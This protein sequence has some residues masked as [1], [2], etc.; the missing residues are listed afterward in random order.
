MAEPFDVAVIGAGPVGS[1]AA[2]RMARGGLRVALLEKDVAPGDSTVCAGGLH[3]SVA[4]VVALPDDLIERRLPA[5]RLVTVRGTTEWRF[6]DPPYLTVERRALDRFLAARAE[7][8]GAR[9]LTRA[10]VVALAPGYGALAYEDEAGGRRTLAARAFVFADGPR[11]LARTY[12]G[13]TPRAAARTWIGLEY[14]LALPGHAL[15]ALEIRLDPAALPLG[16]AWCFPKRDHVNVGLVTLAPPHGRPLRA[17]LDALVARWPALAGATVLARKGGIVPAAPVPR[18]HDGNR[19]A[20]GDAAGMTNPLTAGGYVCGFLSAAHAADACL[21]A[22]ASG[23]FDERALAAYPRRLRR[24]AHWVAIRAA[25]VV[26]DLAARAPAARLYPRLLAGYLRLAHA[27]LGVVRPLGAQTTVGVET[28]SA[29]QTTPKYV[30]ARSHA[31]ASSS[32][33]QA[34]TN[35]TSAVAAT[36]APSAG[37]SAT[38]SSAQSPSRTP[39]VAG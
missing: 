24:T 29:S 26:V 17:L 25:A 4:D 20:V 12:V 3:R 30:F 14:D 32:S 23:R 37:A 19:L 11:S 34:S 10:R 2:E 1:F 13:P 38:V 27:A 9:L 35:G 18:L 21:A 15:D 22:F 6:A 7:D 5:L 31:R 39:S 28:R 36:A 33:A 8:A 16:Y